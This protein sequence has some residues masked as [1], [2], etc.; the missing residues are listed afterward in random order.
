MELTAL[1]RAGRVRVGRV[2]GR[3]RIR[4]RAVSRKPAFSWEMPDTSTVNPFFPTGELLELSA[5][6]MLIKWRDIGYGAPVF[7]RAAYLLDSAGLKVKWGAFADTAGAATAPLLDPLEI[8]DELTVLC[9]D[10]TLQP[11]Y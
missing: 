11:G 2:A 5:N 4:V 9:Y 8:C 1:R 10:H 7:Q 3:I 6:V